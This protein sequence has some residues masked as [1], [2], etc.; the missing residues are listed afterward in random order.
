MTPVSEH[1]MAN[2][3]KEEALNLLRDLQNENE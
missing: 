1:D 2:I 3:S